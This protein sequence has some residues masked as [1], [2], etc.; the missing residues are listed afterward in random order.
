MK[1]NCEDKAEIELFEQAQA[2]LESVVQ[3]LNENQRMAEN[4]E[5]LKEFVSKFIDKVLISSLFSF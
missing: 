1:K 4:R 3:I 2:K 5:K